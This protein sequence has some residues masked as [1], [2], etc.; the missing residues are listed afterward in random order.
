MSEED[1]SAGEWGGNFGCCCQGV[2]CEF[3]DS[4]GMCENPGRLSPE[5]GGTK[6]VF[7]QWKS[8]YFLMVKWRLSPTIF[9]S[10]ILYIKRGN[11]RLLNGK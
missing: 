3:G 10:E 5:C 7:L 1:G 9:F 2:F 4:L 6:G 8:G 11:I